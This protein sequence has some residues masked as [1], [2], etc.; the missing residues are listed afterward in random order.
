MSEITAKALEKADGNEW[1]AFFYNIVEII[2]THL[3][4]YQSLTI[5]KL[6]IGN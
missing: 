5:I 4:S 6:T 3:T 2:K 1:S